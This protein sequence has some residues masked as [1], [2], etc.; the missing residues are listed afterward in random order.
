MVKVFLDTADIE[1]IRKYASQV[2]GFTC[3][4]SIC[5]K[6]GVTDYKEFALE[7]IAASDGKP[8]SLEV[9]ADDLDDMKDQA[10]EIA[11]WG[12]NL[13]VKIPI[14]NT[15]GESTE[16]VIHDLTHFGVKVNV[17]AVMTAKQV[18]GIYNALTTTPAIVSVFCG[19]I[20]DTG[21]DPVRVMAQAG[22]ILRNRPNVELLWASV[23]EV[24]S[25]YQARDCADVITLPPDL[26]AKLSMKD[27][28]LE[29]YS[30]DTVRGFYDD[31]KAA[32]YSL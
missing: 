18:D 16:G 29:E 6:A 31:A 30:L 25:F 3:N 26:F 2:D 32:G 22:H 21:R 1:L 24:F 8:F 10:R 14:T 27:R 13:Y 9:F 23:R 20:A 5:R 12:R 19:R 15:L 7:A 11:S 28:D 4:P 17:T